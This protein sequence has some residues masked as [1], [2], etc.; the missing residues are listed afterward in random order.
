MMMPYFWTRQD[1]HQDPPWKHPRNIWYSFNLLKNVR[2]DILIHTTPLVPS[3]PSKFRWVFLDLLFPGS[4]NEI[5]SKINAPNR[6][7]SESKIIIAQFAS[8]RKKRKTLK[9]RM[10]LANEKYSFSNPW[11]H[12]FRTDWIFPTKVDLLKSQSIPKKVKTSVVVPI[13]IQIQ[14]TMAHP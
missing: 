10:I 4:A 6:D 7:F 12:M 5:P 3:G 8:C 14:K 1:E 9:T 11:R 2:Y 13:Q